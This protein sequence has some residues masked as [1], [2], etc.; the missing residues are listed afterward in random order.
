[1]RNIQLA[2]R[3]KPR[4]AFTLIE[5]LVVIAII[6]LLVGLLLPAL[7][8]AR[9]A[10]RQGVCQSNQR[11]M[12]VA[13][14]LYLTDNKDWLW[15]A[16]GWG[17][18][19]RP[20]ADGPNSL[21]QYESGWLIKYCN[22]A[23]KITECPGNH[24]KSINGNTTQHDDGS[25]SGTTDNLLNNYSQLLWDYT[26]VY[27]V[28][29]ARSSC[30]TKVGYLKNPAQFPMNQRPGLS[31]TGDDLKIFSGLPVFMEESSYFN[32]SLTN[33]SNDPDPAN[34]FFGLWGGSRGAIAGDQITTRHN[35]AGTVGFLQ[36]HAEVFKAP[37]GSD[38]SIREDG[39]L[40][41]DDLYVTSRS[42]S[43]GWIPLERRKTQWSNSP[44]S[45]YGF[46]WINDPK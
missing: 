46:G 40:E 35:G 21:V 22:E 45:P 36:G 18:W 9:D 32:N 34:T 16:E 3:S 5:L 8:H 14:N 15:Q 1:M 39:D 2:R 43:T 19:G 26:M 11:Q 23:D 31:V 13:A 29:G 33:D 28:E 7:A 44:G 27:R 37:H 4:A 17:K 30:E 6:A 25:G 24:R 41:A 12:V 42:N 10:A 38:E 20:I